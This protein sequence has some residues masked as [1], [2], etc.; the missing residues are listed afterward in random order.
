NSERLKL[1]DSGFRYAID[2]VDRL[3][4]R[5][6]QRQIFNPDSVV[7]PILSEDSEPAG[8]KHG[9]RN[10]EN[11]CGLAKLAMAQWHRCKT[12]SLASWLDRRQERIRSLVRLL[13]EGTPRQQLP[14]RI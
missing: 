6:R 11:N 3:H 10:A 4:I 5:L 2:F 13:G 1:V 9:Q 8:K 7:N 14:P 12:K